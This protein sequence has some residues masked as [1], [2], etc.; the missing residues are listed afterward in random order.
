V[1]PKKKL[2]KTHTS[3]LTEHLKALEQNEANRP[4]RS[5]KQQIIKP[6]DEELYK[7]ST[8]TGAGSLRKSTR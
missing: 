3:S 4:K 7:E 6:R 1:P 5:R 8:K 2:E